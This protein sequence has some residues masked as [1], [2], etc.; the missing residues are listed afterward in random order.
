MTEKDYSEYKYLA[1]RLECKN[2]GPFYDWET[3]NKLTK[4]AKK[5]TANLIKCD[6]SESSKTF[7]DYYIATAPS[8]YENKLFKPYIDRMRVSTR[9]RFGFVDKETLLDQFGILE[10]DIYKRQFQHLL[11]PNLEC[12]IKVYLVKPIAVSH[13]GELLFWI[14]DAELVES[15]ASYE[16]FIQLG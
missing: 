15:Y 7:L 2:T 8:P 16:D 13:S 5:A 14:N 1:Y 3:F 6:L 11:N 9:L 10:S 12:E 4:F